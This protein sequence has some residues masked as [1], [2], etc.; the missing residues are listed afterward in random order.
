MRVDV[1]T[2]GDP[3]PLSFDVPDS[4]QIC[5]L[6]CRIGMLR[7]I[8]SWRLRVLHS[9][10][11]LSRDASLDELELR[12]GVLLTLVVKPASSFVLFG[13][14]DGSVELWDIDDCNMIRSFVGHRMN[15]VKSVDEFVNDNLTWINAVAFSQNG[16]LALSGSNDGTARLWDTDNGVCIQCYDSKL[17]YQT[18]SDPVAVICVG[19]VGNGEFRHTVVTGNGDGS[20]ML[21]SMEDCGKPLR[22]A[23]PHGN[24]CYGKHVKVAMFSHDGCCAFSAVVDD[25]RLKMWSVASGICIKYFVHD[26]LRIIR[27]VLSSDG[28]SLLTA[29]DAGTYFLWDIR[30]GDCMRIFGRASLVGP[31]CADLSPDGKFVIGIVSRRGEQFAVLWN[32]CTGKGI[33]RFEHPLDD[34]DWLYCVAFSSDSQVALT[35]GGD[36]SVRIWNI[37]SGECARLIRSASFSGLFAVTFA[38]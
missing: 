1:V 12:D 15:E 19:F 32:V 24:P 35:G 6:L 38:P 11:A 29:C 3:T 10:R 2:S 5:E 25:N 30:S 23:W 8:P 20:I 36:G 13:T 4:M 26:C 7:C 14:A 34:F 28:D 17:R 22:T 31:K 21:W 9:H 16:F 18:S 37:I 27:A 33:L